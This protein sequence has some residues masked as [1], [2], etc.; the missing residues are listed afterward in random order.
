MNSA[1]VSMIKMITLAKVRSLQKISGEN[2]ITVYVPLRKGT[3]GHK[4]N[5]SQLH[6]IRSQLKKIVNPSQFLLVNNSLDF[7]NG[8]LG[9]TNTY[10][11]VLITLVE[12]KVSIFALP[13]TPEAL[14]HIG[15]T[16]N[17]EQLR[18]FY[19]NNR[20]Y[21]V[22]TLSKNGSHL[23]YGDKLHLEPVRVADI[24]KDINALL[25]VDGV[26]R[27]VDG[28][29]RNFNQGHREVSSYRSR[30]GVKNKKKT[31][32][33]AYTKIIDRRIVK[34]IKNKQVPLVIAAADFGQSLYR[35]ITEYPT[36]FKKGLAS[37]PD[38]LTI[39]DLHDKT[40]QLLS[41]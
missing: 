1:E 39:N 7:I 2:I 16:Y 24:D 40:W 8:E 9:F 4:Q 38:S 30:G 41:S 10:E 37:N 19:E 33:E 5:V 3:F 17:L 22:L 36:L 26:Q 28:N 35:R 32:Y 21:Y 15:A 18:R 11:G 34:Y 12:A 14:V 23:Y 20:N 25:K 13:F 27:H 29:S 6:A 31:L